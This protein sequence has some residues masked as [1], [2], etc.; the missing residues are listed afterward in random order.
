MG[1]SQKYKMNGCIN[2][3]VYISVKDK[4]VRKICIKSMY[5]NMSTE[6]LQEYDWLLSTYYSYKYRL[7]LS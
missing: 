2:M 3:H 1:G 7:Y 5:G 6:I 4:C